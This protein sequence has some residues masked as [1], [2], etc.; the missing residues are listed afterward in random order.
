[1]SVNFLLRVES[2]PPDAAPG[3]VYRLSELELASRLSFFLWSSIPDEELLELSIRGEL[4]QPTV[5]EK[6]VRR[7]LA[8]RRSKML[9]ENFAG[10]WLGFRKALAWQPDANRFFEFDENLRHALVMETELFVDS[11]LREDRSVLDLL[12]ADY[13]FVNERLAQHYGIQGVRGERFRRVIVGDGVRGGV[14]GQGSI[15]M[16]TSYPDRTAPVVRGHWLLENI[17]GM[18]PPP[19]PENVPDLEPTATDGRVLSMREQMERHRVDPACATC[20]VRMDPLGFALENFDAV[21]RWRT[22][23]NGNPIDA[24]SV[25]A[26]GT[27]I[28][29]VDGVRRL[30]SGH[31]DDFVRTFTA[32]LLT[33]ALGRRVEYYDNPAIRK[34][35]RRAD[36]DD[37]RWSSIIL[38]IV[39][40]EP[41][42]MGSTAS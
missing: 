17:L 10:Q 20:H 33:Y 18:P 35:L 12:T 26:D 25:F 40:S 15:L 32:K 34:I 21:G 11:Q 22:M 14:L 28:D 31:S 13:T 27:P 4:S 42:Q 8:D 39:D 38:G 30:L 29:G 16:V 37:Y 7:M 6:Q 5:L 24:S 3:T 9:V 19:P 1:M 41:F 23:S 2:P 36:D